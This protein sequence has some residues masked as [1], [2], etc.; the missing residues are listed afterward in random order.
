VSFHAL[1]GYGGGVHHYD[2]FLV[3]YTYDSGTSSTFTIHGTTGWFNGPV[4]GLGSDI[5]VSDFVT[6]S[7]SIRGQHAFIRGH[8]IIAAA[9]VFYQL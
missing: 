4:V 9:A 7:A 1:I 6:V 5:R 3:T 8:S 2:P